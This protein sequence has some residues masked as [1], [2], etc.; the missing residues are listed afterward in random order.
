MVIAGLSQQLCSGSSLR[1][2]SAGLMLP[3][4]SEN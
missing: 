4:P 3:T 2:S 1:V